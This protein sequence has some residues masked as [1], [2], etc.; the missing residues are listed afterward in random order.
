MPSCATDLG[1]VARVY[2]VSL[3]STSRY[4]NPPGFL[5]SQ[6]E[7]SVMDGLTLAFFGIGLAVIFLI[8]AVGGD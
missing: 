1:R 6:I 5:T 8:M 3:R 4:Q 2:R 7:G